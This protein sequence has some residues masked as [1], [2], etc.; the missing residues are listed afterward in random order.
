MPLVDCSACGKQ[1]ADDA[2][3]CPHCGASAG[4]SGGGHGLPVWGKLLLFLLLFAIPVGILI[5]TKP[6]E[7]DLRQAVRDRGMELQAKGMM[8]PFALIDTPAYAGRFTYHNYLFASELKFT[9]DD[10]KVV[11]VASGQMGSI[12]VAERW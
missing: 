12:T 7:A 10:E 6:S 11:T 1:I 3:A 5:A 4:R 8:N 9:R 2:A